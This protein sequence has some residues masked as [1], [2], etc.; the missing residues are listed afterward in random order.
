MSGSID[1]KSRS[2]K[3][4]ARGNGE[5]GF[6]LIEVVVCTALFS[7]LLISYSHLFNSTLAI[8]GEAGHITMAACLAQEKME[9]LLSVPVADLV[10]GF[11]E[12]VPL[13]F[14]AGFYYDCAVV[15]DTLYL[16]GY[17]IQGLRLEVAVLQEGG[18]QIAGFTS[19]IRQEIP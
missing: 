18:R 17:T 2:K 19:F 1:L 4:G 5:T 15:P 10:P 14:G 7:I 12:S 9:G 13:Y 16:D 3:R 8:S 11:S 6:T